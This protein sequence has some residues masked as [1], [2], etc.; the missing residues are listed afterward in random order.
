MFSKFTLSRLS[1]RGM[2]FHWRSH[3]S[4]LVG[5]SIATA[6]LVGALLVGDSVSF[7]LESRALMRLGNTHLAIFTPGRSIS[8]GLGTR[9][10]RKLSCNTASV[11]LLKGMTI[12]PEQQGRESRQI[13]HVQVLG[14]DSVFW[15]LSSSENLPLGG[16]EMAVSQSLALAIGVEPGD[17]LSVRVARPGLMPDAAPL[18]SRRRKLTSRGTLTV[19]YIVPDDQLGLFSLAAN[20]KVPLNAFV[21]L[22]W[23]QGK[24][25][26]ARQVNLVLAGPN[27]GGHALTVA[28]A[29]QAL[30]ASWRM[31]DVGISM[32]ISASSNLVQLES[33]RVFFE[34]EIAR[35]ALAVAEG[36]EKPSDGADPQTSGC[37]IGT[38][39]YLVNSITRIDGEQIL[40]TPYSFVVACSPAADP[41]LGPVPIQMQEN[42]ILLNR[43]LA[44]Q[45]A[46]EPGD[47]VSIAYFVPDSYGGFSEHSR[48]F[49]VRGIV[50]MDSISQERDL[51]PEF[52]GLT[53]VDSCRE[54]DIG[55]PMNEALLNDKS[56]QDYWTQHG[57]TPKAFV[58]LDAGQKMWGNRFG[59]L[60]GV[61]FRANA[62]MVPELLASVRHATD[63]R[64]L[65]LVF[66]PVREQALTAV[67]QAMSFAELFVSMSFF[68]VVSALMLSSMLFVFGVQSRAAEMGTLLAVGFRRRDVHL[69]FLSEAAF[70][71]LAGVVLGALLGAQYTKALIWGLSGYWQGAVAGSAVVYHAGASTVLEGAATAFACCLGSMAVALWRTTRQPARV[72]LHS[73][74]SQ[75]NSAIGRR[76]YVVLALSVIGLICAVGI[77]IT[78]TFSQSRHLVSAFFVAGAMLLLSGIGLCQHMLATVDRPN[79]GKVSIWRLGFRNASRRRGRSLACIALLA[80]GCFIVFAV[81]SMQENVAEHGEERWSGT[82]GFSLY[83]ES[84]IAL[85]DSPATEQGMK[86]AGL[87][88]DQLDGA[89]FVAMRKRD[90]DD[91]SCF[92]LNR[93]QTPALLGVDPR[94]FSGRKAFLQPG[95]DD[96]WR[97]L[98][99]LS[100]PQGVV[101]GLAGDA[102]T[103]MWGLEKHVGT[104]K[105]DELLYTDERG[106]AFRVK[107]VGSLPMRLSVFQ[108]TILISAKDFAERYP[109]E[110]GYRAFLVDIPDAAAQRK[111]SQH[112]SSRLSRVGVDFETTTSRLKSFYSVQSTYLAVFLVLGGMGL[113]LGSMG[114]GVVVLRNVLERRRELAL[115]RCVGFSRLRVG[116]L[117]VAE[118][119]LLLVGGVALGM[120][121][122]LVAVWPNLG[123]P[124]ADV[125]WAMLA[126]LLVAI[127][128]T[129][130][131]WIAAATVIAL[132]GNLIPSLRAE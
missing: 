90:G 56:N 78:A 123:T 95:R 105:G 7:T 1:F 18:S 19:K 3:A 130:V 107:L 98:T 6:I 52:P 25:G 40:S 15:D 44:G 16:S 83:G 101:A 10:A 79:S 2:V 72:L 45:L 31:K 38:L 75:D 65:G 42:E 41:E 119:W 30:K 94:D 113:V 50:E 124:G 8:D 88:R 27:S 46:A 96:L 69:M 99:D 85:P 20:Q 100:L 22:A 13:N 81:S 57:A 127:V 77:V 43:W 102:D 58:T 61:R 122:A 93:A 86:S 131:L 48:D 33:D 60:S 23:L 12:K 24:A 117:I 128:L 26:L 21:P 103:A 73:D 47:E 11:L 112:I 104:E 64:G 89:S 35:A 51:M 4:V 125:P 71:S 76:K 106:K 5:T 37:G 132:R 97:L 9:L 54:W 74:L 111:V 28:E 36:R 32:R 68:I 92:N 67:G 87:I 34:P 129:G 17:E 55:M 120:T 59:K 63:P 80:C 66:S 109:S 29:D 62:D 49:L 53:D 121:S 116:G 126:G 114:M 14:V 39:S 84:T 91:A 70:I 118:H 110:G 108:G 82:G 115:L